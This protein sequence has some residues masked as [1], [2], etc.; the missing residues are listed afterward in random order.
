M[1][2]HKF[3]IEIDQSSVSAALV[4][5]EIEGS[6]IR[7]VCSRILAD[8]FKNHKALI[9]DY[10][11][12]KYRILTGADSSTVVGITDS[13]KAFLLSV[14]PYFKSEDAF[15]MSNA[16]LQAQIPDLKP[17]KITRFMRSI[18]HLQVIARVG[19]KVMR[20]YWMRKIENTI[21]PVVEVESTSFI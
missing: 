10:V 16:D 11:K 18:G 20:G 1:L 4:L 8:H 12:A 7:G 9:D 5:A 19:D 21:K 13:V 3:T 6:T 15:F 14:E 2:Q 17:A